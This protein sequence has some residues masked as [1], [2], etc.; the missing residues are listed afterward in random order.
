MDNFYAEELLISVSQQPAIIS[1]LMTFGLQILPVASERTRKIA[2][3][4]ISGGPELLCR[5]CNCL[6]KSAN[7][8]FKRPVKSHLIFKI[9]IIC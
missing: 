5:K 1:L 2:C 4:P 8:N 3:P 7:V 6:Y 9:F